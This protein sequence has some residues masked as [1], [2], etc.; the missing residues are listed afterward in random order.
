M[1]SILMIK[2]KLYLYKEIMV[3]LERMYN[4]P[5]GILIMLLAPYLHVI[6]TPVFK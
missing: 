5:G 3:L 1:C 2:G 6:C 4:I